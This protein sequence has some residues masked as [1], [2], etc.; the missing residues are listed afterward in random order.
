MMVCYMAEV[1]KA[2]KTK[3]DLTLKQ[4]RFCDCYDG[5]LSMSAKTTGISIAY[6]SQL[7]KNPI[8]KK[9]IRAREKTRTTKSVAD[10][11]QRQEFWTRVLIGTEVSTTTLTAEDG[12]IV[13]KEK[14]P[15]MSDRLKA[16][17]LL[18]RSEADFTDNQRISD[19]GGKA[20]SWRIEIVEAVKE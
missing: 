13:V 17:E 16:S 10:R 1:R 7:L 19:P 6:A 15:N 2:E 5:N 11:M 4:Q 3:A 8:V 12:S 20:L 9:I 14:Q 18:G